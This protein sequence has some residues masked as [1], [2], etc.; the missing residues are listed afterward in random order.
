MGFVG[1]NS[2]RFFVDID[3]VEAEVGKLADADAGLQQELNNGRDTHVAA[4]GVADRSILHFG[5]DLR[6]S[7]FVFGMGDS[8]RGV[9]ADYTLALEEAEESLD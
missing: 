3:V 5:E 8:G 7:D 2:E 9:L 1:A 6:G 4:T